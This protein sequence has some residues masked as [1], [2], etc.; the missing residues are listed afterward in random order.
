[1][2]S[3][4][5]Y[6][7]VVKIYPLEFWFLKSVFVGE[8]GRGPERSTDDPG[9]TRGVGVLIPQTLTHSSPLTRP[10]T[11][12]ISSLCAHVLNTRYRH[13]MPCP[14]SK[15][16]SRAEI[17][18]KRKRGTAQPCDVRQLSGRGPATHSSVPRTASVRGGH[19]PQA[20]AS[21]DVCETI[22]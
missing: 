13:P 14:H 20:W 21:A 1:M 22:A 15:V 17:T 12:G 3:L 18:R 5:I 2:V 10:T 19:R 9:T 11:S 6:Y 16:S 4:E 7:L 8:G